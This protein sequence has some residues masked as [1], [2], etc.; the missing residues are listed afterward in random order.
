MKLS[1]QAIL[2]ADH[3]RHNG[4][5]SSWEAEGV[6]RIRR[7]ASRV[8][9]L[10]NAGYEIEKSRSADATGQPYVRYQFSRRQK[11]ALRP[12]LPAR[13][14]EI[15]LRLSELAELY[16]AYCC[17]VLALDLEET[18]GEVT[19]LIEYIKETA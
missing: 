7:L 14:A 19:D 2:V 8:S 12:L 6:Y 10:T 3:L 1:R 17:D 16:R 4:S 11:R 18:D 5:L 13:P 9:E 15:R